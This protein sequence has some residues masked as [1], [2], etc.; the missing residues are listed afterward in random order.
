MHRNKLTWSVLILAAAGSMWA[1]GSDD[2]GGGPGGGGSSGKGGASA[3]S[4]GR[5][6]GAAQA[7]NAG[8]AQGGSGNGDS[9]SGNAGEGGAVEIAGAAGESAGGS[10][11]SAGDSSEGGAGG[12][13][14]SASVPTLAENCAT[15]CAAQAGL[16]ACTFGDDCVP[17]CLALA[18]DTSAKDEYTAMIACE[19]E[20]LTANQYVCS[21]QGLTEQP[22]PVPG[23]DCETLICSWTCEDATFVD[24]NIYDRCGC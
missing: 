4:G 16:A 6:G 8:K 1:C 24:V 12:E 15:V 14:G 7:G 5:A 11:G 10:G 23:T 20:H 13:A 9:G 18:A 21:D 17:G 2:D 19:A 3:G 22:A